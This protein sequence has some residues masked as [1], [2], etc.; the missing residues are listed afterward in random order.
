VFARILEMK[1]KPGQAKVLCAAIKEKGFPI[2]KRF[3]GLVDALC[4]IPEE[5]DDAVVAMSFWESREAAEQYRTKSYHE[6]AELYA[7]FLE[8]GI[9]VRGGEVVAATGWKAKAA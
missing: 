2:L 3:P 5:N 1:T 4:L 8:G 9:G 6:V 7:P